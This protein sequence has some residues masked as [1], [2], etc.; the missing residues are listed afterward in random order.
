MFYHKLTSKVGTCFSVVGKFWWMSQ[1]RIN[2]CYCHCEW[3]SRHLL[4]YLVNLTD[5]WSENALILY[6]VPVKY[7]DNNLPILK[8][9]K[10]NTKTK[11]FKNLPHCPCSWMSS[12]RDHKSASVAGVFQ[13]LFGLLVEFPHHLPRGCTWY[14]SPRWSQ[15]FS[16]QS[17][18]E[19]GF[20]FHA[21]C[22][23]CNDKLSIW[24]L[25][26]LHEFPCDVGIRQ[27]LCSRRHRWDTCSHR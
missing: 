25:L 12:C 19:Y 18:F 14:S 22:S 4:Q 17:A 24:K 20:S 5:D 7:K 3:D 26:L 21:E 27:H 9:T 15:W 13:D 8:L 11:A 23:L 1:I 10:K 16:F 2:H 6:V